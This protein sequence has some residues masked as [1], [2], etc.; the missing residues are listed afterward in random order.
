MKRKRSDSNRTITE[1]GNLRMST[2]H[3]IR[4]SLRKVNPRT[5]S[6][7]QLAQMPSSTKWRIT[8]ALVSTRPEE[9]AAFFRL[10]VEFL[11]Y[12][13]RVEAVS[14]SKGELGRRDLHQFILDRH[15]GKLEYRESMLKS[16]MR[17]IDRKK[18]RR[19]PPK[20]NHRQY[21]NMLVPDP[22]RLEH[23]LA[24]LLD[25]MNQLYHRAS[26]LFG[27]IPA[28]LRFLE[29]RGLIDAEVRTQ[30]LG[31]LA[32]LA[33][34]LRRIFDEYLDDPSLDLALNGWRDKA[35]T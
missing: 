16:A 12:L 1:S 23:F 6:G 15:G 35:G 18:G 20:R 4:S 7:E 14:Y 34:S 17:D 26:A 13:Q 32:H 3:W 11:G 31:R 19:S 9:A 8:N 25:M 24:G 10:T 5:H 27:I 29:T 33:D 22:E 30:T 28:W 21:E 2:D